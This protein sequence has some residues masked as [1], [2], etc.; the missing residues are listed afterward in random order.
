M[1]D[2][3]PKQKNFKK[4]FIKKKV[5]GFCVDKIFFIDYKDISRLKK[6]TTEKGK[7]IPARVSGTCAKH[8]RQLATAIKRARSI[9]LLPFLNK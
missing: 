1:L 6:Y 5:C 2:R 8:Q 3:K 4:S 7:I 9:A